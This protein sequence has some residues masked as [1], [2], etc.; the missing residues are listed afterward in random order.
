MT[1]R[2]LSQLLAFAL[3][4][5]TFWSIVSL[6]GVVDPEFAG[7]TYVVLVGMVAVLFA[8]SFTVLRFATA[9]STVYWSADTGAK[10][11]GRIGLMIVVLLGLQLMAGRILDRFGVLDT[12]AAEALYLLAFTLVPAGFLQVGLVKWPTRLCSASKLKLFVTGVLG[13]GAAAAWSYAAVVVAPVEM[14]S[15]PIGDWSIRVGSLI[16]GATAEEVIFRV[17]LLTALLD[18]GESRFQAV[19]LSSVAFGLMHAPPTLVQSLGSW[20]LLLEAA[21]AYAPLFLGQVAIGAF[22]GVLWLRSGSIVL[23]ALT[24]TIFNVGT[25]LLYL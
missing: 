2:R 7:T 25:A 11:V 21:S 5:L 14:M 20:P 13:I 10:Q 23:I 24:H 18:L 12:V 4:A 6:P 1:S 15:S 17:L 19:F 16:V 22:L 3:A 9:G 8:L